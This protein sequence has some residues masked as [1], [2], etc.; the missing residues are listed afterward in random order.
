MKVN[1]PYMLIKDFREDLDFFEA[2][3]LF[4]DIDDLSFHFSGIRANRF[5]EIRVEQVKKY[6]QDKYSYKNVRMFK[7]PETPKPGQIYKTTYHFKDNEKW[8]NLEKED[9]LTLDDFFEYTIEKC[10]QI[11]FRR[12]LKINMLV[13]NYLELYKFLRNGSIKGKL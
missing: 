13:K 5:S 4:V 8:V 7:Y 2:I 3:L 9:S 11:D 6:S 1:G 10:N 12:D